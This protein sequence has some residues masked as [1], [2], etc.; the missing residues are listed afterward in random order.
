MYFIH[1]I[2]V[3]LSDLFPSTLTIGMEI[4]SKLVDYLG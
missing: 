3:A 1:L 4:R 2:L